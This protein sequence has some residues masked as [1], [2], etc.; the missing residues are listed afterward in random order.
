MLPLLIGDVF[1]F[2]DVN[3]G[4]VNLSHSSK[5]S[6]VSQILICCI[7]LFIQFNVLFFP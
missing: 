2:S 6:H 1:L 5:F 3:G 4:A 7:C